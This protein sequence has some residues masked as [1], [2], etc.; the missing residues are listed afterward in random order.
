MQISTRPI[1]LLDF[2][3]LAILGIFLNYY[4]YLLVRG[5]FIPYGTPIFF[6][7]AVAC[8]LTSL[9]Q[10]RI[11]LS[12][13][14]VCWILYLTLSLVTV[15]FAISTKTALDG[16]L[17][18]GQRLVIIMMIAYIC[19]KEKSIKFAVRLLAVTAIVCMI[20]CFCQ[21]RQAGVR[22]GLRR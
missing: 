1:T 12:P 10:D 11:R 20:C 4:G 13:E 17:K 21:W 8:T 14:I 5:S 19:E 15:V 22:R 6:A 2:A 16:L 7:I 18:F 9:F 3:K